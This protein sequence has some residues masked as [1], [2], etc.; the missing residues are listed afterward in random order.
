MKK[1]LAAVALAVL[2]GT[3]GVSAQTKFG[4]I[5][6]F[7]SSTTDI[8]D[9]ENATN[10]ALSTFD[11][12]VALKVNLGLGFSFQPSLV[13]Q[14]KSTRA[15]ISEA[16]YD[17]NNGYVE[18]PLQLA[19]GPDLLAFRPYFFGE[20]F[21]GYAVNCQLSCPSRETLKNVWKDLDSDR[22]E[23]GFSLGLG[24]D[25]WKFQVS[26]KYYWNLGTLTELGS[27]ASTV[28]TGVTPAVAAKSLFSEDHYRGIVVQFAIFF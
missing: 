15:R 6:G 1:V 26:A 22:F 19:W 20:P 18:L 28:L 11:A 25:I 27:N 23:Y 4:V 14:T 13:Y 7:T 3:T 10:R 17:Y 2:L 16:Q 8:R 9:I 21:V 24:V 12:G 5:G